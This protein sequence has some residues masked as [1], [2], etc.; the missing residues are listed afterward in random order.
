MMDRE[1]ELFIREFLKE[2]REDNAAAGLSAPVGYVNWRDLLRPIAEE[3]NLD[4]DQ[5]HDLVTVAQYHCNENRGNCY[6]NAVAESLFQLLKRERIRRKIYVDREAARRDFFDCIELFYNTKRR[7]GYADAVPPV[8][9]EKQYFN[10]LES[11]Y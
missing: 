10:R 7:H 8:E 4:I 6:D 11:V 5:E 9:F 3:L 2:V 1:I